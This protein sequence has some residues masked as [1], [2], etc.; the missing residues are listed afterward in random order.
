VALKVIQF[1]PCPALA[2]RFETEAAALAKLS[3]PN[4]VQ[5]YDCGWHAGRAFMAMELLDG[6][7]LARL[8]RRAGRLGE[9]VAWALAR[10]T[11][12]G[13]AHA[14]ARGVVHRDVKPENLFLVPAPAGVGLPPGVPLVKVTDF[15]LARTRWAADP[16]GARLTA[17]GATL[18]TPAYMAPEQYRKAADADHR[19]DVYALG[20]TVY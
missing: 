17:H 4:V 14:A 1:G 11:A 6:E 19:A 10:Q 5:V 12:A 8:L 15:G 16:D 3:H 7:D 20:A 18:G 9:R 2:A 13:L